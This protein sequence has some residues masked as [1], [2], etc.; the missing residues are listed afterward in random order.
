M[1]FLVSSMSSLWYEITGYHAK[2][3]TSQHLGITLL[4][5]SFIGGLLIW[6]LK[7][8]RLIILIF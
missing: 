6:Y 2:Q 1:S 7:G 3:P 8:L 5:M 4:I